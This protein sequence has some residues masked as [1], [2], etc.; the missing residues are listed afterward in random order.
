VIP[1]RAEIDKHPK[2]AAYYGTD[3]HAFRASVDGMAD[4]RT[5]CT[6]QQQAFK[7]I[8]VAGFRRSEGCYD[9]GQPNYE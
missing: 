8:T 2:G 5:S 7:P 1:I 9:N 4:N 6:T 3:Y